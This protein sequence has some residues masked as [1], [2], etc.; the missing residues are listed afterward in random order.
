MVKMDV[1]LIDAFK[2][3]EINLLIASY[4]FAM[5]HNLYI[6]K[7]QKY[8]GMNIDQR[9]FAFGSIIGIIASGILVDVVF[10]KKRFLTILLLNF[11]ITVIDVYLYFQDFSEQNISP[12]LT[13]IL[14][15][16]MSSINIVYLILLPMLIAKQHSE[17]MALTSDFARVSYAGTIVGVVIAL[18]AVGKY[19][20]SDNLATLLDFWTL[21]MSW[22][23]YAD[24]I[25]SLL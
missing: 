11:L 4:I 21:D 14:G 15:M 12:S 8:V 22:K 3:K 19:L 10:K 2:I 6:L 18:C 17:E 9:W 16:V 20:F 23:G 5:C 24:M 1:T 25:T 13:F 7:S